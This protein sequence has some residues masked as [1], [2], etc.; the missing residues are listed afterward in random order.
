MAAPK[1]VYNYTE[2]TKLAGQIDGIADELKTSGDAFINAYTENTSVCSG[3]SKDKADQFVL[4]SE[5]SVSKLVKETVPNLLKSLA[6]M[7]RTN[8]SSMGQTDTDLAG[9]IPA[10]LG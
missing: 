8:V 9:E 4:T 10:S 2:M 5:N 7:L 3:S 6:E 1:I